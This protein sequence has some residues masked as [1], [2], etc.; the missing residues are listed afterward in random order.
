[1][2]NL[3]PFFNYYGAKWRAAPRYPEPLHD[4]IVEPFAGAAGY[5]IR[6]YERQIVLV[7]KDPVIC[8][9]WQ[10]LIDATP[11]DVMSLPILTPDDNINDFDIPDPAKWLIGFWC[12]CGSTPRPRLQPRAVLRPNSYWGERVRARI[13]EQVPYIKHWHVFDW[14]YDDVPNAE[15]TWFIDPPY[16]QAGK[17]Y[18]CN[19]S[20]I[21][22]EHLGTWCRERAGQVIVCENDGANWLPF[23]KLY[24]MSGAVNTRSTEVIWTKGNTRRRDDRK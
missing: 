20:G 19:S 6:H 1:M 24:E 21:D 2:Q 8:A 11:D 7:D 3:R 12:H 18:R 22:F 13:A 23:T 16:Q 14:S 15:S 5:S 4:E 9:V 17:W 10:W